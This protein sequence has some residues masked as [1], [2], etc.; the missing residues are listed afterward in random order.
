MKRN[1]ICFLTLL[2]VVAQL[3]AGQPPAD[4][5]LIEIVAYEIGLQD[6]PLLSPRRRRL[7]PKE[8]QEAVTFEVSASKEPGNLKTESEELPRKWSEIYKSGQ[9]QPK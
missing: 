5:P 1:K 7:L 3:Y 2:F 8:Q 6:A 4:Q 9:E